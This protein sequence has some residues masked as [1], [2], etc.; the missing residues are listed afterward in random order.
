MSQTEIIRL[1]TFHNSSM[2]TLDS[3]LNAQDLVS[4][5]LRM[6]VLSELENSMRDLLHLDQFTISGEAGHLSTDNKGGSR[7]SQDVVYSVEM[8]KYIGDKVMVNY[9]QAFNDDEYRVGMMYEFNDRYSLI[10]GRDTEKGFM[11]GILAKIRF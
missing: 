2:D 4:F 7:Q 10:A 5:G 11:T 1:L 8:G 6:S 3:E 9:K